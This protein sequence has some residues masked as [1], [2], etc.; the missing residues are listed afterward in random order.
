[1]VS[2]ASEFIAY[3]RQKYIND[4]TTGLVFTFFKCSFTKAFPDQNGSSDSS[5]PQVQAITGGN[6]KTNY[7]LYIIARQF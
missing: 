6:N 2:N 5:L 1:M 7:L 4:Q 3:C